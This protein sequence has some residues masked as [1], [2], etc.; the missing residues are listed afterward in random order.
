MGVCVRESNM[1]GLDLSDIN[2]D[3]LECVGV[4]DKL[5]EGSKV[6]STNISLLGVSYEA[7]RHLYIPRP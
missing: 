7:R 1:A 6:R 4:V 3:D 5:S 2:D